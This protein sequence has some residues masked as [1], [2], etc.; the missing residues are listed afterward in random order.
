MS[1][2]RATIEFTETPDQLSE[3]LAGLKKEQFNLRFV[4]D[5]AVAA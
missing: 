2:A 5:A 4:F 3:Q 1:L